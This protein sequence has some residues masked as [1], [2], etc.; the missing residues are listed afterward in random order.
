MP[1][2]T[3]TFR[4]EGAAAGALSSL[5][6]PSG[7]AL[8]TAALSGGLPVLLTDDVYHPTVVVATPDLG[9]V[10]GGAGVEI[11]DLATFL[12]DKNAYAMTTANYRQRSDLDFHLPTFNC[13][14]TF[15]P[16]IGHGDNL[17]DLTQWISIKN[18]TGSSSN[19]PFPVNCP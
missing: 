15:N 13:W 18:A 5:V 12:A 3:A 6:S 11:T 10:M 4:I 9:G 7:C 19:G 2:G 17:G 16:V 8:I 1:G 14:E